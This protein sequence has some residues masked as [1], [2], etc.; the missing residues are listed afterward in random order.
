MWEILKQPSLPRKTFDPGVIKDYGYGKFPDVITS[1]EFE[2]MLL[3]GRI[4]TKDGKEP[5]NL[6]IIHCVGSRNKDYH[7]YCSRV[8]CMTALKYSNQIR[9][10]LP[11][12]NI[13]EA[14]A[15]MR[16][17]G[18]DCEEFYLQTSRKDVMFM[19]FDKQD[20]PKIKEAG[21]RD[22]CKLLVELNE[23]LC[24]TSIEVPADMVIL[25]VAMEAHEMISILR[26]IP[27]LILWQLLQMV[28]I[29][30]VPVRDRKIFRILLPRQERQLP[31]YLQQS[32]SVLLK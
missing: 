6:A 28:S 8:C 3:N 12:A 17:F 16:S 4:L 20:P 21:S 22:K 5:K 19:M 13:Y 10:A 30:P 29:L 14:Y 7:E 15:D 26:N 1:V 24:G 23:K 2:K 18:K 11:E 9:S 31:E 32:L 25:M 27:N